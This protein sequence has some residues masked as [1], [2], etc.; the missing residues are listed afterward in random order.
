MRLTGPLA[1]LLYSNCV[2]A[3]VHDTIPDQFTGRWGATIQS[4]ADPARD[5]LAVSIAPTVLTFQDSVAR[6]QAA[7]SNGPLKIAVLLDSSN[8]SQP[9]LQGELHLEGLEF[10]LSHDHSTLR[11]VS[12]GR[13]VASRVRCH[14]MAA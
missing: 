1:L 9:R 4:C 6:V 3:D 14:E 10:E 12:A 5:P 7:V 13:P 11:T 8:A 2:M